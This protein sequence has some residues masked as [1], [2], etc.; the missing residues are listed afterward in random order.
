MVHRKT[1]DGYV[2]TFTCKLLFS[3]KIT[4]SSDTEGQ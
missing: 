1:D 4:K 3:I 2:F